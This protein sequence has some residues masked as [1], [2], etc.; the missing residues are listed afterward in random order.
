MRL[1]YKWIFTLLVALSVQFSFAQEKTVTGVV[2]DASGSLP[3]ANVKVQGTKTSTQTDLNGKYT[4]VA[5]TGD[6]LVFSFVGLNDATAKVGAGSVYNANLIEGTELKT[7]QVNSA[8]GIKKK[9]DEVTSSYSTVSS[10]ELKLASNPDAVRALVGKVSGLTINATGNG[11]NGSNS[12]RIR[13][14]LSLTGGTEALIVID[15]VISTT[16]ILSTLPPD[17]IENFTILKGAQGAA[18]YGSQ[19][20]QGVVMVTTKKG[21]KNGKLS[22]NF[23]SS[24]DMEEILFVPK[25]QTKYGQGWYG[26]WDPQENGGWG[27]EFDG[28]IKQVG[29]PLPDGSIITAPYS[30]RGSD[31]LKEFY[32]TGTIY[33]N[34]LS[35]GANDG[36]SF[37]N[38]NLG[39]LRRNFILEGDD[40]NRN[41]FVINAGTKVN[42]L[43]IGAN[44]SFI[45]QR[46]RQADVNAAT[47]RGD[48]TL[49]TTLLQ[50]ASNVPV[51]QFKDRGLYGWNGYYQNPWW[52]KDNN[53]LNETANK[54]ILGINTT[55]DFSKNISLSYN[56]SVQFRNNNQVNFANVGV[57]PSSA[58]ADFSSA[59]SFYRSV[60]ESTFYYGDFLANF[61][62]KLNDN[63]SLKFNLGQNIQYNLTDRISQGGV[64]LQIPGWYHINNVLN[65]AVPSSL[66]N[67]K[68]QTRNLA[69]FANADLNFKDYLFF[70]AT[71]RY[72]GNSV[73]QDKYYFY[74]SFGTALS[75]TKAIPALVDNSTISNL[76]VYGNYSKVGSL[77]PISAYDTANLPVPFANFPF[78]IPGNSFSE[79]N[80]YAD[81]N[82]RPE[83]Y[84]TYEAGLNLGLFSDRFGIDFAVFKTN[85][86]D[87]ITDTSVSFT[88][89]AANMKSN[90]GSLEAKGLEV[91]LSFA[92]FKNTEFK[93]NGRFNYSTSE[94]IVLDAGESNSIEIFDLGNSNIDG[95]IVATDG[96][97]F[98]YI[99]GT[100][101]IRDNNGNVIVNASGTPTPS[102]RLGNL[103]RAT[104]TYTLGL[105]N[106]FEYK[107]IGLS[108]TADYRTGHYFLSQTKYNLTWNGHL[109]D[110]GEVDRYNGWVQFPNAVTVVGGVS[111]PYNGLTGGNYNGTGV[112]NRTQNYY[113]LAS[114]LGAHNLIDATSF[115][116]REISLSFMLPKKLL[117]N[118]GIETF[119]FSV[120]ARNPFVWLASGN[121][122][123][124]DPENSSQIDTSNSNAARNANGTLTNS[125][126][127]GLG[128]IG[129]ANYPTTRTLGF[130]VNMSF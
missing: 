120:N 40:L 92:P 36:N 82:I 21:S 104:P 18:L 55:Y 128:F 95:S 38:L 64:N 27:P 126:R 67:R 49:L 54:I 69:Y 24:A 47:S 35:V 48:Y 60:F 12:I 102:S 62:Y 68:V 75:L 50:T 77:D 39:N 107:G 45:N 15:N 96:L 3:G 19:G 101:W 17:A 16:D 71:G 66:R 123:Y 74:P 29:L 59:S 58:D 43:T 56:G 110:S 125:S 6:V 94:T 42:K 106:S 121:K 9:R 63:F 7:V 81:P 91:D 86:T 112:A 127:N 28:S 8:L 53:R 117:N 1:K 93:W 111:T 97:P 87:L 98:P 52:A 100:D 90:S 14:M 124:A 37:F 85:T 78:P 109:D 119:K 25:K 70:N 114:S 10:K 11:V 20:K 5:K 73:V 65:P 99:N 57:T 79:T 89:G 2:S 4:I 13:S 84:T 61:N 115:R 31:L 30:S 83:M 105:T 116:I 22:V 26:S 130:T 23:N 103:G 51:K 113:G 46:S 88:T 72:E 41:T 76:K 33:Q 44:F 108:F 80:F 118:T 34:N 129:D 122:G 32:N